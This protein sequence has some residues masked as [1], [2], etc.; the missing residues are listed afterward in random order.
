MHSFP[1]CSPKTSHNGLTL[2]HQS[3]GAHLGT[4]MQLYVDQ[5]RSIF[6][7]TYFDLYLLTL[8]NWFHLIYQ[9]F[10]ANNSIG[11]WEFILT[12]MSL[13]KGCLWVRQPT[14]RKMKCIY[15]YHPNESCSALDSLQITTTANTHR[16]KLVPQKNLITFSEK[17]HHKINRNAWWPK[18]HSAFEVYGSVMHPLTGRIHPHNMN[19][20][21]WMCQQMNCMQD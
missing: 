9:Y 5:C 17:C 6:N 8:F 4:P 18:Q 15:V 7:K 3:L 20:L 10:D 16:K 1:V 2:I 19:H 13:K 11:N 21:Q 12:S 14:H